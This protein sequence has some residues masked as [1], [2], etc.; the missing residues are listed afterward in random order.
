MEFDYQAG[1]ILKVNFSEKLLT[2][3]KDVR[4]LSE[5]GFKIPRGL[6]AITENA[7]KFYREG[8]KLKKVAVFYNSMGNQMIE[9]Q[10]PMM[11]DK[12]Q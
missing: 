2:L 10:K 5:M 4:I 9:C 1:G 8:V 11:L 7:K 6:A 3:V 12:A